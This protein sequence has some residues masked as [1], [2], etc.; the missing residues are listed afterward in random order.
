M[1]IINSA[2]K[3]NSCQSQSGLEMGA[4]LRLHVESRAHWSFNYPTSLFGDESLDLNFLGPTISTLKDKF[5]YAKTS[6]RGS[7][8]KAAALALRAAKPPSTDRTS[9]SRYLSPSAITNVTSTMEGDHSIKSV[10]SKG[11][12]IEHSSGGKI[13]CV[14]APQWAHQTPLALRPQ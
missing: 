6:T 4:A 10:Q 8:L 2:A 1:S 3:T 12:S 7:S 13:P 9:R 5:P 14:N 11:A